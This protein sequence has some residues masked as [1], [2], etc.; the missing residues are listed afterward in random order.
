LDSEENVVGK[1]LGVGGDQNRTVFD[2]AIEAP[3]SAVTMQGSRLHVEMLPQPMSPDEFLM[4][5]LNTNEDLHLAPT[6]VASF[7]LTDKEALRR[8]GRG[9]P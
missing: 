3:T 1:I 2:Q 4:S 8:H 6:V 7:A 5:S 9:N